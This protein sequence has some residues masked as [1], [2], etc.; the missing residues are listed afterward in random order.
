MTFPVTDN[1][2]NLKINL[3]IENVQIKVYNVYAECIYQNVSISSIPLI[4]GIQIDLSSQ[5]DGVY[6][7][8]LKSQQGII[9]EKLIIQK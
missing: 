4:T 8:Q 3:P 9:N 5:P 2:F 7:I 6:S 1:I